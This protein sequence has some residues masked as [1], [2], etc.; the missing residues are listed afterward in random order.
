[1]TR[2]DTQPDTRH[3]IHAA[4]IYV[5]D[6][7][8]AKS[9]RVKDVKC[10]TSLR[11]GHLSIKACAGDCEFYEPRGKYDVDACKRLMAKVL[12]PWLPSAGHFIYDYLGLDREDVVR[13]RTR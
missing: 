8:G 3:C 9:F 12:K 2:T 10:Q 1:M 6:P 13:R 7:P 11:K 4:V 5:E